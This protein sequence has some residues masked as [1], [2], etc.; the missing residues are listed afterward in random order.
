MSFQIHLPPTSH[1]SQP[2]REPVRM[3]PTTTRHL[4]Q[5]RHDRLR[6]EADAERLA[7][8]ARNH[9]GHPADEGDPLDVSGGAGFRVTVGRALIGLGSAIAATPRHDGPSADAGVGHA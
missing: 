6:A 9:R 1:P 7:R 5:D 2:R 4:V 3:H 8:A